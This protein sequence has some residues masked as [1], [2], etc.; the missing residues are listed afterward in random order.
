MTPARPPRSTR[1]AR[2]AWGFT[3]IE[4][5]VALVVMSVGT[6]TL[7]RL[8][9]S[10]RNGA[11]MAKQRSE[12]MRLAQ[13]KIEGLRAIDGITTGSNAWNNLA[14]GTDTV[15]SYTVGNATVATN[16]TIEGKGA[17]SGLMITR[18]FRAVYDM[19]GGSHPVGTEL[20]DTHYRKPTGLVPQDLTREIGGRIAFDGSEIEPLDDQRAVYPMK[21]AIEVAG[22]RRA[23]KCPAFRQLSGL[24]Q[25]G[26][27]TVTA[28]RIFR[29]KIDGGAQ[30]FDRVEGD[31]FCIRGLPLIP[32]LGALRELGAM[33]S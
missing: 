27:Q 29:L 28:H 13:D 12:A 5:L 32:V 31:Q 4:A 21:A 17:K 15:S 20:I 26:R 18:G 33:P 30:L 25:R 1:H 6:L 14:G 7:S 3:L 2:L 22:G 24:E 11:D 16:A 10:M 9:A 23:I 8:Q 19:R